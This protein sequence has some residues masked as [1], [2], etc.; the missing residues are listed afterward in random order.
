[1]GN[2]ISISANFL[3]NYITVNHRW[4]LIFSN[5]CSDFS[6]KVFLKYFLTK[7]QNILFLSHT[8][9]SVNSL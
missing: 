6:R 1:M 3:L 5:F 2:L 8:L 9:V 4:T 7:F